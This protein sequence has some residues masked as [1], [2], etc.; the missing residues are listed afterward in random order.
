MTVLQ[1]LHRYYDRMAARGEVDA[2]EFSREKICLRV[3]LSLEGE[4]CAGCSISEPGKKRIPQMLKVPAAVK[5][6]VGILPN[7]FW[8]KTSY[9]LGRTA[10]PGRA[11]GRGARGIQSRDL[12]ADRGKQRPRPARVA[13]LSREWHRRSWTRGPAPELIDG[14]VVFRT[15]WTSFAIFTRGMRHAADPRQGSGGG[16]LRHSASSGCRRALVALHPSIKGSGG[17]K[18]E[19]ASLVSFNQKAFESYGKEQGY[20][21]PSSKAAAAS[22]R[23][24]AQPHAGS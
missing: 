10:W 16:R 8:D 18:L 24:G 7:R 14:N 15:R 13:P 2:P 12:G 17:A 3:V 22:L 9:A 5:R 1:S 21:A 23:R 11:N 20:N 4:P 6:T 19:G